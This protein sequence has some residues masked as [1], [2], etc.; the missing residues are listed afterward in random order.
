MLKHLLIQNYALIANL[1]IP[2][3][4]GLTVITGETGAG[5]SILLGA[6]SLILGERADTRVLREKN[7]KCIIEGSF[8]IKDKNLED[9]FI[10]NDL[11][12]ESI[13]V[14]RREITPGGKS[15]AFINDTPVNLNVMKTIS[16]RLIDIHSQHES[17]LVGSS[18]FQFDVVDSYANKLSEVAKYRALYQDYRLQQKQLRDMEAAERAARADLDYHKFQLNELEQARLNPDEYNEMEE[19]IGIQ[20]HAEDI[21]FKLDKGLFLLRDADVNL[22]DTLNEVVSLVKSLSDFGS[23]YK[24]LAERLESVLIETKDIAAE[25]ENLTDGIVHDPQQAAQLEARF[26]HINKLMLKHN[27]ANIRQLIQ[28]REEFLQ[29]I[30]QSSSLE[31]NIVSLRKNLQEQEKELETRASDI[32]RFRAEM[33]PRIRNEVIKMLQTLAMPNAR[34]EIMQEKTDTLNHRGADD[35]KFLFS[36]NPGSELQEVSKVASGGEMSRFMLSIKNIISAR[37]L[38]PTIIFDEIDTGISGETSTRVAMILESMAKSMQVLTITHLPQI[39][40]RGYSHLLVYKAFGKDKTNTYIKK[41]NTDERIS[42]VAKMLGGEKPTKVML[43]TAKE[44]IFKQR[45]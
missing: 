34:F 43:E 13:S 33:I 22:L 39:A 1:D 10:T 5:K 21:L 30:N 20:K 9:L 25:S 31:K 19:E 17:L 3:S 26:D 45:N 8:L 23:K 36:A 2:L 35:L 7:R 40:S 41:L 11:D 12:F 27:A 32:S 24:E 44:L 42:E 14:F 29:K 15:R 6:L 16:G 4:E 18:D 38:L 37:N 28:T